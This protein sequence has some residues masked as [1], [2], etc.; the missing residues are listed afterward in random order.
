MA[1]LSPSYDGWFIGLRAKQIDGVGLIGAVAF[2]WPIG[3]RAK[4]I[5]LAWSSGAG[6]LIGFSASL[7]PARSGYRV[8]DSL[9]IGR[10]VLI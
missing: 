8:L 5:V 1:L 7:R 2:G 3:L 9:Q 10:R 4:Q 6:R